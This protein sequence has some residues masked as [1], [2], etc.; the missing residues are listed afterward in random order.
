MNIT[1][2]FPAAGRIG[3][4]YTHTFAVDGGTGPY[5]WTIADGKLLAGLTLADGTISGT[6]TA[7]AEV[8]A[9][10]VRVKDNSQQ[11]ADAA[12][13]LSLKPKNRFF[14]W[15]SKVTSPGP[16]SSLAFSGSWRT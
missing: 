14:T 9:F 7:G 11:T 4:D 2:R 5:T 12:V 1:N 6:P 15:L 13:A 10:L 16:V 8:T 3:E